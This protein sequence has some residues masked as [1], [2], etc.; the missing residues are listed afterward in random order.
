M[1][2]LAALVHGKMLLVFV[3][4]DGKFKSH[5]Q[6]GLAPRHHQLLVCA[7][8]E[9]PAHGVDE[10]E[11]HFGWR[12]SHQLPL[13]LKRF[14]AHLHCDVDVAG[15]EAGPGKVVLLHD[16]ELL[17]AQ[18]HTAARAVG[19]G[20]VKPQ[21]V[22]CCFVFLGT[23]H[24]CLEPRFCKCSFA[25]SLGD[26][27]RHCAVQVRECW[28]PVAQLV[29]HFR[30]PVVVLRVGRCFGHHNS[31]HWLTARIRCR[32]STFARLPPP[33][34]PRRHREQALCT[35]AARKCLHTHLLACCKA[36]YC[37]KP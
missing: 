32:G 14:C 29:Y 13:V 17:R 28:T 1:H 18:G 34:N 4:E 8:H 31:G 22:A 36:T 3:L 21:A 7:C 11:K 10:A 23:A 26:A 33:C 15:K 37:R 30:Q 20:E 27:Q 5:G 35:S 16:I 9:V 19:V 24:G 12:D 25:S 6:E 2:V